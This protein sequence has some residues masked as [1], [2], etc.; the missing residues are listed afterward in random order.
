MAQSGAGGW[1]GR[2]IGEVE[3]SVATELANMARHGSVF[4]KS[5]RVVEEIDEEVSTLR[6]GQAIAKL[7]AESS[8]LTLEQW[9]GDSADCVTWHVTHDGPAP[10][11][12]ECPSC[13]TLVSESAAECPHCGRSVSR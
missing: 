12:V 4:V 8:T 11:G 3:R 6:V 2:P 1:E 9:S 13:E 7:A 5:S 10:F